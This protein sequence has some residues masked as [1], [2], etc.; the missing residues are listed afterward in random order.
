MG[1]LYYWWGTVYTG[2]VERVPES[3]AVAYLGGDQQ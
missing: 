3:G 2:V 1:I